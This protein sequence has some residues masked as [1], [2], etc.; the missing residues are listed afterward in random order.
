MLIALIE[1]QRLLQVILFYATII[2]G[3]SNYRVLDNN[4][5]NFISTTIRGDHVF[6]IVRWQFKNEK[7][8]KKIYFYLDEF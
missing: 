4:R 6:F 7:I 8:K 5:D 3:A 1:Y 2:Y